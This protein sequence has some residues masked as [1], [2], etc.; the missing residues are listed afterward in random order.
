MSGRIVLE[1]TSYSTEWAEQSVELGRHLP[2]EERCWRFQSRYD[3]TLQHGRWEGAACAW[4]R[5]QCLGGGRTMIHH[6]NM[7][8]GKQQHVTHDSSQR[9]CFHDPLRI[10]VGYSNPP[11]GI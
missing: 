3:H 11:A 7:A 10:G 8:V 5:C 2:L 4:L 9:H 1:P 6:Q